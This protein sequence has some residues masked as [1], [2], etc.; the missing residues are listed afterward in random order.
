MPFENEIFPIHVVDELTGRYTRARKKYIECACVQ[1]PLGK[2]NHSPGRTK[3]STGITSSPGDD[4]VL[5]LSTGLLIPRPQGHLAIGYSVSARIILC[6]QQKAGLFQGCA[7]PLGCP[8]ELI[9]NE[10]PFCVPWQKNEAVDNTSPNSLSA[11]FFFHQSPISKPA[12]IP[13]FVCLLRP[14]SGNFD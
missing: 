13:T 1:Y 7:S 4:K 10:T 9:I 6:T 12:K 3:R 8:S 14:P 5:P 2:F 11:P